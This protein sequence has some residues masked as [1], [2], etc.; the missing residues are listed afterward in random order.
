MNIN[1]LVDANVYGGNPGP[2]GIGIIVTNET[3]EYI[4]EYH[5]F[6]GCCTYTAGVWQA[7][8]EGMRLVQSLEEW[9]SVTKIDFHTASKTVCKASGGYRTPKK[10]LSPP[11]REW[12][13]LVSRAGAP[14]SVE[15]VYHPILD[16]ADE[17]ATRALWEYIGVDSAPYYFRYL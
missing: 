11:A 2:C 8:I 13:E 14:V 4:A 9:K 15:Y 3:G 5:Q 10:R 16:E 12:A 17:A 7:L 1:V 6:I